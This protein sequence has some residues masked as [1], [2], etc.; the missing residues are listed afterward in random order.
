M[1][2]TEPDLKG[3]Y[4][5]IDHTPTLEEW[6]W[7]FQRIGAAYKSELARR[8]VFESELFGMNTYI[9]MAHLEDYLRMPQRMRTIA[10]AMAPEDVA[11]AGLPVGTKKN[12]ICLVAMPL[13]Y[14]AG[15]ELFID[16]GELDRS[17][18]LDDHL[19]VLNFWRRA[20]IA[21]RTDGVLANIDAEPRDSSRVLEGEQ[22]EA[23]TADLVPA[24]D[25]VRSTVRKFGAQLMSYCFL[26]NCDS[27]MAVCDTGPYPLGREGGLLALRELTTDATGDFPWTEGLRDLLPYHN[28][29]IA[30][31]LPASVKMENNIWGTAWFTPTDYLKQLTHARVYVTDNATLQALPMAELESVTAALR[32]AHKRLYLKFSEMSV[33]DR[34]ICATQMYAWKLKSWARAA[35]CFDEI[36]W[37]LSS[38]VVSMFERLSDD[39]YALQL[40]GGVF[41]P[42]SRDSVWGP[43]E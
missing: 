35:G 18:D 25:E 21:L 31:G 20:T 39:D 4:L 23:L 28:F 26:E 22:L 42:Q 36:D 14:L 11:R 15:R 33:R 16:L 37:E 12:F 38:R 41:V 34:T 32:Q 13:H 1:T 43:L 8:T 19:E 40:L 6:N 5:D 2:T 10:A 3:L 29:V 9:I 30:Y 24:D 17:S 7:L 27:R